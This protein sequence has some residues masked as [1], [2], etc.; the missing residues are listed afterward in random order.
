MSKRKA[1]NSIISSTKDIDIT[2]LPDGVLSH[3]SGYVQHSSRQ[4]FAVAMTAPPS[5]FRIHNAMNCHN[6]Q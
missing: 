3:I 6:Q 4:L 1:N 2:S 5:S